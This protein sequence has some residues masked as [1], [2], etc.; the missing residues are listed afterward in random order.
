[1]EKDKKTKLVEITFL[2]RKILAIIEKFEKNN[3]SEKDFNELM[4]IKKYYDN[5][6]SDLEQE[7]AITSNDNL[8]ILQKM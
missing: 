2:N 4:N 6:K 3:Y 1:M 7:Y 8:K 5:L